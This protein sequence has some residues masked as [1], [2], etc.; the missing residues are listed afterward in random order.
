M[1]ENINVSEQVL[2]DTASR[3][4]QDNGKMNDILSDIRAKMNSLDGTWVSD[5]GSE[6]RAA[7]NAMQQR[8]DQY[9]EVI[10]SYKQFL[11]TTADTY[12]NVEDS[13]KNM[14]SAFK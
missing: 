5:A 9:R 4:D 1:A 6:I 12:V 8:F 11:I 14:A 13:L 7:M 2:R 10:D 3:F